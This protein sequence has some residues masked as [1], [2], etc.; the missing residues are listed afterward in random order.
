MKGPIKT[1]GF[2]GPLALANN[3]IMLENICIIAAL[4]SGLYCEYYKE[5]NST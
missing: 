2:L 3:F 4:S 1:G 5:I